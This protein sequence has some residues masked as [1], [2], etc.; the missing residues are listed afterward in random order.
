MFHFFR[1]AFFSCE[2]SSCSILFVLLFFP[3]AL[4]SCRSFSVLQFV[5]AVF[6]V[7]HSFHV[8]LYSCCTLFM[9]H[10]HACI[11]LEQ[12]YFIKLQSNCIFFI[13]VWLRLTDFQISKYKFY[14]RGVLRTLP[15]TIFAKLCIL[16]F[17]RV[18]ITPLI[19]LKIKI[20]EKLKTKSQKLSGYHKINIYILILISHNIKLNCYYKT[21]LLIII[22]TSVL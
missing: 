9:L 8:A 15:T 6:I 16:I 1:L 3:I 22:L 13:R 12:H 20:N 2:L 17:D 21:K 11:F 10:C 4:V 7:L 18:R 5:H 19:I 14:N